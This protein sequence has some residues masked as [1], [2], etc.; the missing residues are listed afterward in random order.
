MNER[1]SSVLLNKLPSKEKDPGSFTIP[2]DIGHLHISNALADLGANMLE[3]SK[4]PI[5]LGIPFLATAQ[6]MIDVFN[7][8]ITL[9]V[10]NEEDS[11]G[12]SDLE[13]CG[14]ADEMVDSRT[15][16]RRIEEVSPR[17][18]VP[19]KGG[20]TVLL[21]DNNDLI[22]SITVTGWRVCI[23]YR[24]LNDATRFFQIPIAP[25]DQEKKTFT[26]PSGTLPTGGYHLDYAML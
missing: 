11:V 2:Y 6:A 5:I 7:K 26:C 13:S 3:D 22:S 8:K 16:I 9:R 12:L 25:E 10:G 1:C 24:K 23:D 4:I 15:P 19:K 17:H 21:N 20:M 14:K 18:V